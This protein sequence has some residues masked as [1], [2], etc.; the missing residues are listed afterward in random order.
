[1]EE[2][3]RKT[4]EDNYELQRLLNR[5][6]IISVALATLLN[7]YINDIMYSSIYI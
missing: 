3:R 2:V 1:M 7:L 6:Q 4:P 5:S